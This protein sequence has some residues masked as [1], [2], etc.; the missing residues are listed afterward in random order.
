MKSWKLNDFKCG[1]DNYN[2]WLEIYI[3]FGSTQKKY[4]PKSKVKKTC[5]KTKEHLQKQKK[6]ER[7]IYFFQGLLRNYWFKIPKV[8]NFTNILCA[9]VLR[10]VFMP[11]DLRFLH[12]WRKEIGIK[13]A[14]NLLVKLT[15][16][17]RQVEW[18]VI[19][20]LSTLR[21]RFHKL[22]ARILKFFFCWIEF[23]CENDEM[24]AKVGN[25]S[26]TFN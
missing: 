8:V 10:A 7:N 25:F 6:I 9:K 20:I 22:F 17:W 5:K 13:T 16:G 14:Y 11:F 19:D 24:N 2:V 23:G 18:K 26:Q 3:F 4:P 15:K 12:F 21:A 1:K